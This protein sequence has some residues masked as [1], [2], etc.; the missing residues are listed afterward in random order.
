MAFKI[1]FVTLQQRFYGMK[2]KSILTGI[3]SL[4]ALVVGL[5]ACKAPSPQGMN[6]E[7]K[8]IEDSIKSGQAE[9]AKRMIAQHMSEAKDSDTYYRWLSVQNRAWYAEMN[10]DSMMEVSNRINQYLQRNKDRQNKTRQVI[11]A[12]W[13]KTQGVFYSAILG[14]PDSALIFNEKAISMLE[15]LED[16]NEFRLTA[17]NNQAF[18]YQQTGRYDKS[19]EYYI[20][21]LE[22]A[23]TIGKSEADKSPLLL[24]ISTV[25]TY[26]GDYNRSEYWWNRSKELLPDMI[27]ADQF[28]YY[29]DRGNDYYFQEKYK[30][31]GD[32][33]KMAAE[34]V[35]DDAMKSWDYYTSLTNLGEVYVCLGE[36]DSAKWLLAKADS[37]F[38]KLDFQP[39]L[40]YIETSRLKLDM[41]EGHTQKAIETLKHSKIADP[42]IPAARVQRLKAVEQIMS[43]AGNYREA[44]EANQQM[45]I[46]SD[47]LQREKIS[48]QFST[49]LIEYEHDKKLLEQQR[50]IDKA[51]ADR[52]LA[53]GLFALMLL[54]AIVL[55]VLFLLLR[56]QQRFNE[57]KTRQE[58]M[59]MRMDTIRNRIT[60]HFIYNALNH[61]VLAQMEGR[62]VDLNSLTQLLRRG[63][64]QAGIFQT[65]LEEELNFVDYYLD[66]EGKQMG[67]DF[68]YSKEIAADVDIKN[69]WL[70]SMTIQIFAENALKHGLK[71]IKPQE[72]RLRKLVIRV[73]REDGNT[74]VEV[75]DNG[76]G[77]Q[78]RQNETG[79]KTGSRVVKQTIQ[80]LNDNN[81]NKIRFGIE[82][83]L[84]DGESGCRSW[85]LLPDDYN[86]DIKKT[87]AIKINDEQATISKGFHC[88]RQHRSCASIEDDAGKQLLCDGCRI[89]Q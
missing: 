46:L 73:S 13:Y 67:D 50:T 18:F 9:A 31:A 4:S 85:I 39:I 45:R 78:N 3:I 86:Y 66:I 38:R 80:M 20:E 48:M 84:Q 60:P 26:M 70:P 53:W 71:P 65:T 8:R 81:D 16:Q 59:T 82:N 75:T 58:I 40:Y 24:G 83:W 32:C 34:L 10:V 88:R 51:H 57:L 62:K 74:L 56:R 11:G 35:K 12:E 21:A 64:D 44:Y 72:G 14:R 37:F 28:I 52:L 1:L 69:V 55:L 41:L 2:F 15:T 30:E 27:K 29:N 79:S 43:R 6:A 5:E 89:C 76:K 54:T 33:Y 23:D 36:A 63:V 19:V 47:S 68:H 7:I 17:I 87:E 49:K 22:L 77:L 61:E 42:M 25:Y